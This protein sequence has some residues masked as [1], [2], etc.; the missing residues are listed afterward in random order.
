MRT[1]LLGSRPSR[2]FLDSTGRFLFGKHK[3][4]LSDSVAATDPSYLRWIVNDVEDCSDEDREI[5][6]TLLEQ[7]GR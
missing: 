2:D 3:G 4:E 6:A 7:R 5:L 1:C